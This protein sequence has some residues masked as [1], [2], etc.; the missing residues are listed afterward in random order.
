MQMTLADKLVA[1]EKTHGVDL[2]FFGSLIMYT[3]ADCRVKKDELQQEFLRAGIDLKYLPRNIHPRDAYRRATK[4]AQVNRV[5]LEKG[6]YLNL[7]VREVKMDQHEIIRKLVREVVNANNERLEYLPIAKFRLTQD[8]LSAQYEDGV[9]LKDVELDKIEEV[10]EAYEENKK[11][12]D[13]PNIA[14][15]IKNILH[16][17]NPV[18]IRPTGGMTFIPEQF[19]DIVQSV[20]NFINR[21][22]E[23]SVSKTFKSRA[24]T[25]PVVNTEKQRRMVEESLEDQVKAESESL[26]KE[27]ADLLTS[28]KNFRKQTIDGF[29][30]R[31]RSLKEMVSQY[32]EMLE[33]ESDSAKGSLEIARKQALAMLEKME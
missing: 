2:E 22:N 6:E 31:V 12:Y 7:L 11:C 8:Q 29:I 23:Y 21:L 27:M 16:S 15:L 25:V 33:Y 28:G 30:A 10:L 13:G 14:N 24:Y 20:D 18:S 17:C 9:Q 5:P 3:I 19:S 1:V 26:V 4:V 32:E